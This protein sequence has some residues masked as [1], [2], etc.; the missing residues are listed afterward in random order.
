[1]STKISSRLSKSGKYIENGKAGSLQRLPASLS[2]VVKAVRRLNYG[3]Y[4]KST[5]LLILPQFVFCRV[6]NASHQIVTLSCTSRPLTPC[7]VSALTTYAPAKSI[8]LH[9]FQTSPNTVRRR[10]SYRH[11]VD[12]CACTFYRSKMYWAHR[13]ADMRSKPPEKRETFEMYQ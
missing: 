10:A 11:S 4:A 8:L 13:S 6:I 7:N 9:V 5:C 2:S 1:M 12:I 3:A